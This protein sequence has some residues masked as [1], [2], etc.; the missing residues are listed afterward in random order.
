MKEWLKVVGSVLSVA[1]FLFVLALAQPRH[2]YALIFFP[3]LFAVAYAF[4]KKT[5]RVAILLI[6]I[7]AAAVFAVAP[8]DVRFVGDQN[9]K[10]VFFLPIHHSIAPRSVDQGYCPGGCIVTRARYAVVFSI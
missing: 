1:S 6:I 3:S 8:I 7:F 2:F 5:G 4:K 10:G 9:K